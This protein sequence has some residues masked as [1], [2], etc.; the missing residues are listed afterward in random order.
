MTYFCK[1][2]YLFKPWFIC[3]LIVLLFY[4]HYKI[5]SYFGL[6]FPAFRLNTEIYAESL[7]IQ[8]GCGK[9]Q[10]RITPNMDTF[11]TV[12]IKSLLKLF[13]IVID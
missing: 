3:D 12:G 13:E 5:Q 8:S 4:D 10:T 7:P 6:H 11:Y 2:V 1:G 9:M